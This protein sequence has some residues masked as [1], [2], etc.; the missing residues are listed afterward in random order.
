MA[1]TS[2]WS[3]PGRVRMST[4]RSTR[5]GM[6]LTLV[7][8]CIMVGAMVVW[9]QAWAWRARPS[10]G[11]RL[12]EG[13]D[14]VGVEQRAGE[15]GGEPDALDEAPPRVVDVGGGLV[16]GQAA[17]DLGRLHQG[18]VG[19]QRLRRVPGRA[20]HGHGAPEGALLPGDDGQADPVGRSPWGSRPPR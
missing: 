15:L 20:P 10:S 7:P 9:V 13:A 2:A 18:V 19:A 1:S 14:A 17:D 12:A 3:Q 8:A 6:T 16:L 11:Q 5:S 4:S